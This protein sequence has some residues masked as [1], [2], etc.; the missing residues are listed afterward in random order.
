MF[1]E[2]VIKP[3]SMKGLEWNKLILRVIVVSTSS[4]QFS[5]LTSKTSDHWTNPLEQEGQFWPRGLSQQAQPIFHGPLYYWALKDL[6]ILFNTTFQEA[7]TNLPAL[8]TDRKPTGQLL[9]GSRGCFLWP[10]E[11]P[12]PIRSLGKALPCPILP[13]PLLPSHTWLL[14]L[15]ISQNTPLQRDF[16]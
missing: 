2:W 12:N 15:P 5:Q 6:K 4:S 3:P 14:T 16:P 11:R 13:F 1:S 9:S 8:H 7:T 10:L